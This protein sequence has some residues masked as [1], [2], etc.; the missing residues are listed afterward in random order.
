MHRTVRF[1]FNN[2]LHS[3]LCHNSNEKISYY[4]NLDLLQHLDQKWSGFEEV[5]VLLLFL[6]CEKTTPATPASAAE[7]RKFTDQ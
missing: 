6:T 2:L 1:L 4:F 3:D 7:L 5:I